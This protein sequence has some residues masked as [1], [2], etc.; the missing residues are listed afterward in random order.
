MNFLQKLVS[1]FLGLFRR[2]A[3]A[4]ELSPVLPV[5]P[6]APVGTPKAEVAA[7]VVASEWKRPAIIKEFLSIASSYVGVIEVGGDN[8]GP[9]V[10]RFQK[11]ADGKAAGEPWCLSFIQFCVIETERRTARASGLLVSEHV[12]TLWNATQGGLRAVRVT[13]PK[14]GDLIVWG[15]RDSTNGHIGIVERSI[16]PTVLQTIEG[17]TTP[18]SQFIPNPQF[19]NGVVNRNGNG[20]YRKKRTAQGGQKLRVLGFIRL[21]NQ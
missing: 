10:E 6:V 9:Q 5:M 17:N 19:I 2:P 15:E 3:P 4:V 8:R 14:P 18:D 21:W 13:E 12:R 7:P 1:W 20:V 16:N 11:A